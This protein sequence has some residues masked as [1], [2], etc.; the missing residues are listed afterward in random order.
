M[1]SSPLWLLPALRRSGRLR[2]FVSA[3]TM[4]SMFLLPLRAESPTWWTTQQVLIPGKSAD[5]FAVINQGQLKN[6]ASAAVAEMSNQL[7]Q[8]AGYILYDLVD[9]WSTPTERTDDFAA[10]T[11]GQLKNVAAPVYDRLISAGL[12]DQ[13]P[14]DNASVPTHAPDDFALAN[15]GQAKALFAFDIHETGI[16]RLPPGWLKRYN[17]AGGSDPSA[18][19]DGDG[20]THWQEYLYGTDPTDYY[21]GQMPLLTF[22]SGGGQWGLPSAVLAQ[23]ISVSVNGGRENA[24]VTFS[25]ITGGAQLSIDGNASW[26][27]SLS[28]RSSAG[29]SPNSAR[30]FVKLPSSASIVST[31]TASAGPASQRATIQTT[32]TTYDS[33]VPKPTGLHAAALSDSAVRLTWV[34]ADASR[35]TSIEISRDEG[36]SWQLYDVAAP[37]V[38]SFDIRGLSLGQHVLLRVL[39]GDERQDAPTPSSGSAGA[40]DWVKGFAGFWSDVLESVGDHVLSQRHWVSAAAPPSLSQ[41]TAP[42]SASSVGPL[43]VEYRDLVYSF[44]FD[45]SFSSTYGWSY[46]FDDFSGGWDRGFW[47]TFFPYTEFDHVDH[48]AELLAAYESAPFDTPGQPNLSGSNFMLALSQP[49]HIGSYRDLTESVDRVRDWRDGEKV[50]LH[51]L[52]ETVADS[53]GTASSIAAV[54]QRTYLVLAREFQS[55]TVFATGY[56][57]SHPYD[58]FKA[59]TLVFTKFADGHSTIDY[60]GNL[61]SG[62]VTLDTDGQKVVIKTY[63][64][65]QPKNHWATRIDLAPIDIKWEAKDGWDNVDDNPDPFSDTHKIVGKRIFPD[66]LA[67]GGEMRRELKLKISIPGLSNKK[68]YLKVFD[69]D[70][71]S[72]ID[73]P[74]HKLDP[75]DTD[76]KQAGDDNIRGAGLTADWGYFVPQQ[77]ERISADLDSNGE[78]KVEFKV[79]QQPG[80]NYRV[81][82]A[83]TNADLDYLQVSD[84]DASGYVSPDDQQVSGFNGGISP[85]LTVWRKLHIEQDSMMAA[86]NPKPSPDQVRAT[87]SYWERLA[88]Q[89]IL[90]LSAELPKAANFYQGGKI[91]SGSVEFD[92]FENTAATITILH[93]KSNVPTSAQFDA[94]IG[95]FDVFDDD[96]RGTGPLLPNHELITEGV[97]A[98]YR[99]AFIELVNVEP[100]RN[101]NKIIDFAVNASPYWPPPATIFDNSKDMGGSDSV[102]YWYHFVTA[103]YQPNEAEDDDPNGEEA[104]PGI[105]VWSGSR[106]TDFSAIFLETVRDKMTL[107]LNDP[108]YLAKYKDRLDIVVSHEIGHVPKRQGGHYEPGIMAA[109]PETDFFAPESLRR[110]RKT[111]SWDASW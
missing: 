96:E 45:G 17:L 48:R 7:D 91:K 15:I 24:P 84:S 105:T 80:N 53:D 10:V 11:L 28:L 32:V 5:D 9:Q 57:E 38:G 52:S 93:G 95:Q 111:P 86:P 2:A 41:P 100:S 64:P 22:L 40:W 79:N 39:T 23:P 54:D 33:T 63:I 69:V 83:I 61:P 29:N 49:M 19:E 55:D 81:A 65:D 97:K 20:S 110:F 106:A 89:S 82:A 56:S 103:A 44:W 60:S 75:N 37:G 50:E 71:P 6:L 102:A 42:V 90:H 78:A 77:A 12:R 104:L 98:K 35:A 21:N 31:I 59:G 107:P 67:P 58:V 3:C 74:D 30:V 47:H 36:A 46:E 99:K 73:D 72:S 1:P 109:N 26:R 43:A 66:A 68:V 13:Y 4:A 18:D 34:P 108:N 27:D 14:W 70:D 87:G 88:A 25:V 16:H 92:F 85:M 62:A 101:K 8:G 76:S 51:V 94:F